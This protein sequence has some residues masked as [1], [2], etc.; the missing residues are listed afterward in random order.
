MRGVHQHLA[1]QVERTDLGRRIAGVEAGQLARV[2]LTGQ[3][4]AREAAPERECLGDLARRQH[5]GRTR[6]DRVARHRERAEYVDHHGDAARIAR[7]GH[8]VEHLNLHRA[9][10][11]AGLRR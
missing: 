9:S 6:V 11:S 4:R 5:P 1:A 2:A 7:T 10:P 8:M 3:Q